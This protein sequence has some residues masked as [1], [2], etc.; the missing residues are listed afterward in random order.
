M[1]TDVARKDD[2]AVAPAMSAELVEKFAQMATL[3]PSED[4]SGYERIVEA[5]L[6]AEAVDALDEPWQSTQAEKLAGRVLRIDSLTRRPS[7]F[8]SG[9]GVFLVV[10]STDTHSGEVVTWTTGSVAIVAQLVRAYA[11][12]GLPVYAE[13]IIAERPTEAGYRPHHLKFYGPPPAG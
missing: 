11:L 13:L 10:R 8:K 4:G 7:D 3:I 1:G 5:I 2:A 6:S 12:G 9:L